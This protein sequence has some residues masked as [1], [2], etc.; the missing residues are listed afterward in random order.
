MENTVTCPN[1]S[2]DS[3]YFD[4]VIFICPDCT[5]EWEDNLVSRL[6]NFSS[7]NM[8]KS[9]YE[10]LIK[11][12]EPFFRLVH[13]KLYDC[14][15]ETDLGIEA[16]SIIPLSFENGRNRQFV[17]IQ[18]RKLLT[19]YPELVKSIINMDFTCLYDDGK[20]NEDLYE[21]NV[22][23]ALCSTQDDGTLLEEDG[24]IFFNFK[25]VDEF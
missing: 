4:G 8:A 12:T 7:I 19:S 2:L 10:R 5:H 24:A 17:L 18:G 22:I 20:S 14:K 11:R 1:C 3:A 9:D 13:G 16:M 21:T 15:L 23:T 25:E 6:E